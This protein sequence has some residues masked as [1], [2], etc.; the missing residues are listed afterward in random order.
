MG[1]L[2][3]G[4]DVCVKVQYPQSK[5]LR[6]SD[7]RTANTFAKSVPSACKSRLSRVSYA[8]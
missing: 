5:E 2:C 8:L 1:Q 3:G 7:I 4:R 6:M